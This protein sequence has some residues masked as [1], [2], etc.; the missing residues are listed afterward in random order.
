MRSVRVR[1]ERRIGDGAFLGAVAAFLVLFGYS[2]GK[3]YPP[4]LSVS[5]RVLLEVLRSGLELNLR[6]LESLVGTA[7]SL[8]VLVLAILLL[9]RRSRP[10]ATALLGALLVVYLAWLTVLTSCS[11]YVTHHLL[12]LLGVSLAP[13]V[14]MCLT[15]WLHWPLL[16]VI[17]LDGGLCVGVLIATIFQH[18]FPMIVTPLRR[19]V[20]IAL[21]SLFVAWLISSRTKEAHSTAI[22][23]FVRMWGLATIGVSSLLFL[24]VITDWLRPRAAPSHRLPAPF[25]YDVHIEGDPPE[26]VWTDT[27]SIHVLTDPYGQ[28]HESYVL[29][30]AQNKFPQRIWPS[31]TDGFYVQML[32]GVGWWKSPPKGQRISPS[33]AVQY[34]FNRPMAFVEDPA[35]GSVFMVSQ[36]ESE[37]AVMDR[38]TG[39]TRETGHISTARLGAWHATPDL[40]SRTVILSSAM[41]DGGLYAL[42]LDTI[43]ITP[44]ASTV[45]LYATV[46]DRENHFLWGARLLS[47]EV[48]ALD[49][50]TFEVLHRIRTGFGGR[51]LERDPKSGLLYTCSWAGDVFRIDPASMKATKIA[52]CG[53]L[54]R[55]VFVDPRM[56]TLWVTTDDGICRIP[57]ADALEPIKRTCGRNDDPEEA[58]SG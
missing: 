53:R 4:L 42:N 2:A 3:W 40:S 23:Q 6:L 29:T 11:V 44:K 13:L 33:P 50:R 18:D 1:L 20:P 48:V 38:D 43:A 56:N 58:S 41:G 7:G 26:L 45:D 24:A 19:F 16:S 55:S 21:L 34:R 49:T 31:R 54:C 37:Y 35:T 25:A 36:E 57:L 32:E 51:D 30:A 5:E 22:G 47:G 8:C 12:G 46:L 27:E 52:W 39:D 17:V 28:T 14:A 15:R 9:Y 10:V